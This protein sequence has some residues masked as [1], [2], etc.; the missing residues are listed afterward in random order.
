MA[1]P[2]PT[3]QTAV[4]GLLS[5]NA[6]LVALVGTSIYDGV[7]INT[8]YPYVVIGDY[9]ETTWNTFNVKG[10]I[11]EMSVYIYSRYRGN[12]E[13]FSIRQAIDAILDEHGLTLS[14]HVLVGMLVINSDTFEEESTDVTKVHIVQYKLW[15]QEV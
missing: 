10:K 7:P 3:V 12:A 8:L 11:L 4:Y 1:T 9:K 13:I 2:L 14:G 5:V 6:T 15:T